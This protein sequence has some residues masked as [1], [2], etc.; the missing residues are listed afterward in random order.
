MDIYMDSEE[1]AK[2]ARRGRKDRTGDGVELCGFA[3]LGIS[4]ECA[5]FRM[6]IMGGAIF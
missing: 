1:T 3:G 2:K 5:T 4:K 6:L